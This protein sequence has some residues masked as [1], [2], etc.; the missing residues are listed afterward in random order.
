M[1]RMRVDSLLVSRTACFGWMNFAL[2]LGACWMNLLILDYHRVI[3]GPTSLNDKFIIRS[4]IGRASGSDRAWTAGWL[5][6]CV[7]FCY[8]NLFTVSSIQQQPNACS[9]FRSRAPGKALVN[10]GKDGNAAIH[11]HG[12]T[13]P[14]DLKQTKMRRRPSTPKT[15]R[16]EFSLVLLGTVKR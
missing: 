12:A 8:V 9:R 1:K 11:F 10:Y 3:L 15:R 7:V 16:D 4:L 6:F 5:F 13:D 14:A 2:A